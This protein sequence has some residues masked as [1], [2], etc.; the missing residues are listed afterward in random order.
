MIIGRN[1]SNITGGN[2]N[3]SGP[4]GEGLSAATDRLNGR[5][6]RGG[7]HSGSSDDISSLMFDQG[8]D[9]RFAGILGE[10]YVPQVGEN[11]KVEPLPRT[12]WPRTDHGAPGDNKNRKRD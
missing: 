2:S 8:D 1:Q 5:S 3:G 10:P 12:R 4:V 9:N 7:G 6:A 11:G